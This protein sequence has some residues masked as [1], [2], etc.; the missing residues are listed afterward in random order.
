MENS[1][2]LVGL[3]EKVISFTLSFH[4]VFEN[5]TTLFK[6]NQK[7][8]KLTCSCE[9]LIIKGLKESYKPNKDGKLTGWQ[10]VVHFCL[11]VSVY[12]IIYSDVQFKIKIKRKDIL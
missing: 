10:F 7:T 5:Y 11:L 8:V 12:V 9:H 1:P 6:D 3:G 4:D 2:E